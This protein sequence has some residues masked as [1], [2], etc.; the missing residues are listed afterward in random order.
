MR[1]EKEERKK[2]A[3]SNKQQGKA[4]NTAHPRQSLFLHVHV[5]V[6][7]YYKYTSRGLSLDARAHNMKRT[8]HL[9]IERQPDG[10]T[11]LF[12]TLPC[13]W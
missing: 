3:R 7:V 6:H 10:S 1:D 12:E 2:Q 8:L 13:F 5:H 4:I 11:S 9:T